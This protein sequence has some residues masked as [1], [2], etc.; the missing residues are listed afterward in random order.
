MTARFFC[1][2]AAVRG[3]SALCSVVAICLEPLD[4]VLVV[5][6][7]LPQLGFDRL[8]RVARGD[9]RAGAGGAVAGAS[10]GARRRVAQADDGREHE[11]RGGGEPCRVRAA[12][13]GFSRRRC[14][15]GSADGSPSARVACSRSS[16]IARSSRGHA[17]TG[18]SRGSSSP[19]RAQD[20]AQVVDESAGTTRRPRGAA[21]RRPARRAPS[22]PS[23]YSFRV[24]SF[25]CMFT[26]F[27][28]AETRAASAAP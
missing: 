10:A 6:F 12:A 5:R 8:R 4:R 22:E 18:G 11:R 27:A 17:R 26:V 24:V 16:L 23:A 9:R 15:R 2:V 21:R 19:R 25:G 1:S 14:R 7:G 3:S 13:S 20:L 28:D